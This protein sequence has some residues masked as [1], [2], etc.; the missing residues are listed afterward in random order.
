MSSELLTADE[1][2]KRLHVPQT[3]VYRAARTGDL[4]S[5]QCGRYRRFDE[6]DVERWIS[7]Q[8]GRADT[9]GSAAD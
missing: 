9:V 3:W 7:A 1:V 6:G 4:P 8:K 5:I 2:A